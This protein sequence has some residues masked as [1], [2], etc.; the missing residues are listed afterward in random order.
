MELKITKDNYQHFNS[1][2][3]D[4]KDEIYLDVKKIKWSCGI[5]DQN[6]LKKFPNLTHLDCQDNNLQSL[7]GIEVCDNLISL[8]CGFNQLTSL[9]ELAY[10]V[11][12]LE[13]NCQDNEITSLSPLI[14]C[15]RL[16]LLNYENNPIII[17]HTQ[18]YILLERIE[19]NSELL[20][21][22]NSKIVYTDE[23][24]SKIDFIQKLLQDPKPN[25]NSFNFNQY[26]LNP[27]VV[28]I[29]RNY[30]LNYECHQTYLLTYINLFSYVWQRIIKSDNRTALLK[31]LEYTILN[32]N[33]NDRFDSLI[34]IF[35]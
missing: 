32:S 8:N 18:I 7:L 6:I 21:K 15:K 13:L 10:C 19:S 30:C 33:Y 5:L 24:R 4:D 22:Y 26:Q 34:E 23:E 2:N 31:K 9:N 14:Y 28:S 11:N 20:L 12:L 16:Y 17:K 1:N 3:D 27:E 29:I 25:S 35:A